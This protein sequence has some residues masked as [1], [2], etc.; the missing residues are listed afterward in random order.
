MSFFDYER[1]N[2]VLLLK[3]QQKE[4]LPIVQAIVSK[5]VPTV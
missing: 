5:Q 3:L 1:R 2:N 4:Y